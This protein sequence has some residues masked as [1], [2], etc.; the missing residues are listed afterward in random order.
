M[1]LIEQ[2][3]DELELKNLSTKDE[4]FIEVLYEYKENEG[5][6]FNAKFR[7]E[8]KETRKEINQEYSKI[9]KLLDKHIHNKNQYKKQEILTAL[10]T[11]IEAVNNECGCYNEQYY[12]E[13]FKRWY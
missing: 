1:S 9:E 2:V 7:K 13:R 12:K 4:D 3:I 10:E 6:I 8:L 11:Y 5:S